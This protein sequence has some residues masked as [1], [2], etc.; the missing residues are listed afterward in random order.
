ME[1]AVT[2]VREFVVGVDFIVPS[3]VIGEVAATK[4]RLLFVILWI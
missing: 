3:K 2:P 4:N 1:P